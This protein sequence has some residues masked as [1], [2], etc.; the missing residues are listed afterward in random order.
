MVLE[1]LVAKDFVITLFIVV[2]SFGDTIGPS[3]HPVGMKS[4]HSLS[5]ADV[6]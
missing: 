3:R 4:K 5:E 1:K 6:L 2:G